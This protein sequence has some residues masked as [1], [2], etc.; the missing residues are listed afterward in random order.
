MATTLSTQTKWAEAKTQTITNN[1]W[2]QI[3]TFIDSQSKV[4]T[5]WFMISL[6]VQGVFF[7][8]LPALLSFYYGA[9]VYILLVTLG[10]FFANIIAGMGGSGIR[11]IFGLL[12]ISTIIN[13][14][15]FF[16][17]IL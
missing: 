17:Y 13:L 6:I 7:L 11:A 3:L 15:M 16:F 2:N 4:K 10:L 5:Q 9:P 8:P 14:L 1:N 12:A